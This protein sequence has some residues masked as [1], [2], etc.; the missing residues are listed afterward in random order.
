MRPVNQF[1]VMGAPASRRLA[2]PSLGAVKMRLWTP[3]RLIDNHEIEPADKK[4][5]A[6]QQVRPYH[7][8]LRTKYDNNNEII[9]YPPFPASH[10]FWGQG[11]NGLIYLTEADLFEKPM[12][13]RVKTLFFAA[14]GNRCFLLGFL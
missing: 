6:G 14:A 5:K 11:P 1:A 2:L 12:K 8:E 10:Q 4:R 7:T 3:F 9:P 13:Q